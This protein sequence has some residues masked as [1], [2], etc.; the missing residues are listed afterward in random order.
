ML[1]TTQSGIYLAVSSKNTHEEYS[2]YLYYIVFIY[3]SAS[4]PK[5]LFWM[6]SNAKCRRYF[7][8]T[9]ISNSMQL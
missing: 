6:K 4:F 8:F 9:F 2:F 7:C 3:V 1:P 5:S